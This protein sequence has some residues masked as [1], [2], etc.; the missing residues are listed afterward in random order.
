MLQL[1]KTLFEPRLESE[2]RGTGLIDKALNNPYSLLHLQF[3]ELSDRDSSSVR[4][5]SVAA[6]R[7][8]QALSGVA[9]SMGSC[10]QPKQGPQQMW[11]IQTQIWLEL[12]ELYLSVGKLDSAHAC[13]QEASTIFPISHMVSYMKGRMAEQKEEFSDAKSYYENAVSINPAHV[14]SLQ[15]LG[16]VLYMTGNLHMAEKVL[17]DAVNADPMCNKSWQFLG[18]VLLTLEQTESASQCLLTAVDI[19][20]TNPIM[21][22]STVPKTLQ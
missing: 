5:E 17:R 13:I 20:S 15:H 12:A 14:R 21:P 18:D 7:I 1:W 6:S 22:F 19:E 2:Q 11:S 10:L 4:A 3:G 8:E 16:Q 9:S